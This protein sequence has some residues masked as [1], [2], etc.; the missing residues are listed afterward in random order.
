MIPAD[1]LRVLTSY[2]VIPNAK[3]IDLNYSP[4]RTFTADEANK[5][6]I[7]FAK[8]LQSLN[9]ADDARIAIMGDVSYEYLCIMLAVSQLGLTNVPVNI[10]LPAAGVHYCLEDSKSVL[11]FYTQNYKHL[12]PDNIKSIEIDSPEYTTLH[13]DG[14]FVKPPYQED[15]AQYVLYTSGTTGHPKGVVITYKNR[16]WGSFYSFIQRQKLDDAPVTNIHVSPLYHLA[17]IIGLVTATTVYKSKALTAIV[18]PKFTARDYI[19]AIGTYQPNE[20]KLVAPMM[21]M[22]LAEKKLL[23]QT[24]LSSVKAVILTS[25]LAPEKMQREVKFFFKN[26]TLIANPYGMTETGPVFGDHPLGIEKPINSVG[27]PL[28]GVETRIVDGVLQ[29]KS[30]SILKTYNNNSEAFNKL[31]TDDG[32]FITGDLFRVNKYGF[33]FFQG[34]ADD[35]FK[36]GGEKIYP[37]EIEAVI[38]KHPTVAT[39]AVV[40]VPD[41]IK[42][43]KP[44]AFVQLKTDEKIT[45]EKLKEYAI[46]NVASYQIPREV[47]VLDE[48][49]KTS[50]G[51]IDRKLLTEMAIK[52]IANS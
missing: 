10:K 27:Y 47:W 39:S 9:L 21:S 3:I 25:S 32:F 33:Y 36:S 52:L 31:M 24:D 5:K 51:K 43:Y 13:V 50:I 4:P 45:G 41:K 38:D 6:I 1:E 42:G 34:R 16:V 23:L 18:M 29:I 20:V 8:G 2:T 12:V 40:G 48:L 14:E 11:V 26:T 22:I 19:N 30:N 7:Q 35:M 44:Y 49:P 15:K 46:R 28:D 17:G 37:S